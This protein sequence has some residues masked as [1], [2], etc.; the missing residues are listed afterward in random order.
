MSSL[1]FLWRKVS[2]KAQKISTFQPSEIAKVLCLIL[3]Q[4]FD[5]NNLLLFNRNY[6]RGVIVVNPVLEG[7][8]LIN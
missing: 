8:Y 6:F 3:F 7:E 5:L 1:D 4:S 2:L